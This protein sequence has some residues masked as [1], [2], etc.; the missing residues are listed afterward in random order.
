MR[1]FFSD[2]DR[3]T[4]LRLLQEQSDAHGVSYLAYCL[5]SNHV[6]FVAV[7]AKR[8]SLA[9]ALGEAHRRYT[10][11]VN[12]RQEVRGYL[13]Q[14]RFFSCPLDDVHLLTAVRY[15]ELN[16]VRANVVKRPWA[17]GWSSARYH[18]GLRRRD[19]L[20]DDRDL[21]GR[22]P[23]WRAYL[24]QHEDDERLTAV[25]RTTRT[26]RPCG[27]A[28]FVKEMGRRTGRRLLP[29]RPGPRPAAKRRR[30]PS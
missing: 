13:F 9:R 27:D 17:Y 1:L 22:V 15:V 19:V 26:G 30:P 8:D 29:R 10:R 5:M 14:G 18:V 6:H 3:Q 24:T 12:F 25:R 7:P 11:M 4:Y 21:W 20:V 16:P 23:D 28:A 2:G